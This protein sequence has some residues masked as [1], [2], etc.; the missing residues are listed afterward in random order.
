MKT[1][2]FTLIEL[3]VVIAVIALLMG[4][5]MPALSKARSQAQK[6]W[7]LGNLKGAMLATLVYAENSD[8]YL[9]NSGRAWP[10]M[11]ML[12]FQ[13][14]LVTDS[15]LDVRGLHCPADKRADAPSVVAAW[16]NQNRGRMTEADH[17][18]GNELPMGLDKEV[19]YSYVWSAKM[20]TNGNADIGK[21]FSEPRNWKVS[22][23]KHPDRLMAFWHFWENITGNEEEMPP[24]GEMGWMVSFPDGHS[25]RVPFKNIVPRDWNRDGRQDETDSTTALN[26]RINCDWTPGGIYGADI[27][28]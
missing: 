5:L 21:P 1:K 22:Q 12:D 17:M 18:F 28:D 8:G 10:Y 13:E 15:Y 2:G 26:V 11:T 14:L 19:D 27:L 24:H 9:A 23:V 6:V 25:A 7:C 4:I 20:Y 3:L 16:W